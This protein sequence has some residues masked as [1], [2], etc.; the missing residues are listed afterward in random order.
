MT[1]ADYDA[2]CDLD[3]L[4]GDSSGKVELFVNDGVGGFS[5]EGCISDYNENSYGLASADFEGDGDI[6]V[7]IAAFETIDLSKSIS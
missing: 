1:V 6:D 2:D 7:M 5:S 4:V 3:M